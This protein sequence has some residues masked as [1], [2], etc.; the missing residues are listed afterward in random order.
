[1]FIFI[2]LFISCYYFFKILKIFSCSGMFRDVPECSGMFRQVPEC[3]TANENARTKQKQQTEIKRFDWF[4]ERIQ[5][6]LAFG[7]L[8][9]RSGEKTSCPRTLPLV[10][11]P[12]ETSV[13]IPY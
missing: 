3:S 8:S 6:R 4:I 7:W 5:T 1:M 2:V 11:P 13:E 10:S 9:E 12:N